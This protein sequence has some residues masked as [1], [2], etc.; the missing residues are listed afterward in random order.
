MEDIN[1]TSLG[2]PPVPGTGIAVGPFT[3]AARHDGRLEVFA[4]GGP[5]MGAN[6]FLLWRRWEQTP[7]GA[8]HDWASV[9]T[10]FQIHAGAIPAVA[11]RSDGR[12]E[13]FL[14][15]IHNAL[16]HSWEQIPGGA[17]HDWA[18]V[19][20]STSPQPELATSPAVIVHDDGRLE[21]FALSLDATL[22]HIG[23]Q[24]PGGAWHDWASLGTLPQLGSRRHGPP[25][26]NPSVI[27]HNDGRLEVFFVDGNLWHIGEQ[28]PGGAWH[29]WAS[30]G[31]P[32]QSEFYAEVT[33]SP[34]VIVHRDG[35]LEVFL[36]GLAITPNTDTIES[37]LWHIGEQTP[38]GA[39]HDWTSLGIPPKTE[40]TPSP[41][42]GVHSDGHLEVFLVGHDTV[43][44]WD[45][46]WHIWELTPGGAWHDWAYLGI[47]PGLPPNMFVLWHDVPV[48]VNVARD[49]SR[50]VFVIDDASS[51]RFASLSPTSPG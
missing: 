48:K 24:T 29:D 37:A 21:V 27:V 11:T 39:W 13:A 31:T 40:E 43:G 19:S 17:W 32:P 10:L 3:L 35:R 12:L 14:V 42:V 8:W 26:T 2:W 44:W 51:I 28:T 9:G 45:A 49:G 23:E 47:P 7:G 50:Q 25:K 15:D 1:W 41:A 38:G 6:G 30:L 36:I 46:L 22:W 33:V 16:W 4:L 5:H 20:T 34:S 18:Q